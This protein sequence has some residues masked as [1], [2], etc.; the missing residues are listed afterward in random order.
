MGTIIKRPELRD[1]AN[2]HLRK[3]F[4]K[5]I[6]KA[7]VDFRATY[8]IFDEKLGEIKDLDFPYGVL[9]G[10]EARNVREHIL[11]K[12]E[13]QDKEFSSTLFR[14]RVWKLT[15]KRGK[16]EICGGRYSLDR[17]HVV[18]H[19]AYSNNRLKPKI[20]YDKYVSTVANILLICKNCHGDLDNDRLSKSK[21]RGLIGNRKRAN[22]RLLKIIYGDIQ[23][24]GEK[25]KDMNDYKKAARRV[26]HIH[27]KRLIRNTHIPKYVVK[28]MLA[29]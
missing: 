23:Y 6:V 10:S 24:M 5:Q 14:E 29:D 9:N 19:S 7:I 2:P 17:A 4:N 12:V 22:K 11:A 20:S 1:Y 3:I 25:I 16:C 27:V 15:G 28:D 8:K 18:K 13:Y 21:M 26:S